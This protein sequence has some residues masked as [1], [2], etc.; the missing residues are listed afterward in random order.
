MAL[1]EHHF[2]MAIETPD[3]IK[4]LR[5]L[6]LTLAM[7]GKLVPQDPNDTPASELLK[8][9]AA[10]KKK[11]IKEGRI[12]APKPLPPIKATEIPYE[13]PVGWEWTRLG[14]IG[15]SQTGTTP[16]KKD[17]NNYG[18]HIPFIGP[19]DIKNFFIDYTNNGLSES[20][21]L[22]GRLIPE[23]SIM[24]V[25][26]G[27]SIGKLSINTIEVTCNQQINTITPYTKVDLNY[28]FAVL[29]SPLFQN[30]IQTEASGSATP[31]IN[32]QKW[33][34]IIVPFPSIKMQRKISKKINQLM[35]LCDK[36][37]TERDE[38]N[39]KRLKLH[40]AIMDKLF[41]VSDPTQFNQSWNFVTRHF[42]DIYSVPENVEDLKKAILQLAVMGKLVPQ[43]SDD[44]P[45]SEL[46]KEID[47]EK[48]RLIK[49]GKIKKQKPLP[50]IKAN[51]IPYKLPEGW[52]WC[53]LGT[54]SELITKGS[55]PKWQGVQYTD[56]KDGI[57]FVT[58][59]NVGTYQL[60][61]K[62]KRYVEKTFNTLSPRSIL[63]KNDIL[64]NIV[65]ASIG[66]VAIYD[67][68][69]MANINQA[70]CLIRLFKTSNCYDYDFLLY[71]L[72]SP[73]CI[74]YMFDKQVDNARANLSMANINKFVIPLPPLT[75]QKRIVKKIDQLME[76]CNSLELQLKESTNR[77]TSILNAVLMEL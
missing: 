55:S 26:I 28:L 44:Q 37:E 10:E 41:S 62:D 12:K 8:A 3:G 48:K 45:A 19:G 51:E 74:A 22:K 75:E 57:F 2:D 6:I 13:L 59:K 23:N 16:P 50:P 40:T 72:N 5:E 63:N 60:K 77:Q 56:A 68:N 17:P 32:K 49:E 54:V 61:L 24:M 53:R 35:A 76:L 18:N 64:M 9:I 69:E 29:R 38:R 47:I 15:I 39:Q 43:N 7:Q 52:M 66:R 14:D 36:L 25:C 33:I 31:I 34:S 11:L 65:G 20:G 46:L 1:L 30:K 4:K 58:S 73:T 42:D 21:L 71:F 70:V 27:G 67:L